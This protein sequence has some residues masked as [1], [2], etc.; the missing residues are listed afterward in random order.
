M[1]QFVAQLDEVVDLAGVDEG[2]DC[3]S[4]FLRPHRLG[5]AGEADDSKTAMSKTD[6]PIDPAAARVRPAERH[7]FCHCRD[8][9][10][11]CL[12]IAIVANPSSHAAH[13]LILSR[14]ASVLRTS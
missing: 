9:I 4:P 14:P 3:L 6:M 1:P 2:G 11:M 12:E 10:L 5:A 8:D 7:C 13:R